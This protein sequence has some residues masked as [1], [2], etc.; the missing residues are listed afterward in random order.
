MP[1]VTIHLDEETHRLAKVYAATSGT[2][3]SEMFRQH[4]RR[5]SSRA[6]A[7]D[8]EAA[9]LARYAAFEIPAKDPMDAL[10]IDCLEALMIKTINAGLHLP[11]DDQK[12]AS[13]MAQKFLEDVSP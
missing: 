13:A 11:H 7:E 2:S 12:T 9:I 5:L 1:N 6:A 10:G 4:V 3:L 8:S